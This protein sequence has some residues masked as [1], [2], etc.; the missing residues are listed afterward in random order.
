MSGERPSP[1]RY[2]DPYLAGG[3][4]GLV[5]LAAFVLTGRGPGRLG[6]VRDLGAG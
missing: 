2:A 6:R 3:G 1:R 4:L 5:L